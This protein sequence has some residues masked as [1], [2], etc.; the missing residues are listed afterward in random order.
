MKVS[1]VGRF[2]RRLRELAR[3]SWQTD[4]R[5]RLPET[6]G[7]RLA[8]KRNNCRVALVAT[9]INTIALTTFGIAFITPRIG[10]SLKGPYLQWILLAVAL[11]V[12]SQLLYSFLQSEE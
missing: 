12:V 11:H 6:E 3:R 9:S 10:G 1:A 5:D 8:A 7:R 2:Y 4:P